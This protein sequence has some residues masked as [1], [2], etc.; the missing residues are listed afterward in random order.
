MV[1]FMDK[2]GPGK[3]FADFAQVLAVS[4]IW[5]VKGG[6]ELPAESENLTY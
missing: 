6:A 5:A 2:K 4:C 3:N 1:A